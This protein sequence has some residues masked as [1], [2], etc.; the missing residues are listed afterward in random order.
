[1][2]LSTIND[3]SSLDGHSKSREIG[4][5]YMV[6][7]IS[8]IDLLNQHNAPKDIDYLSIDTEGSEYEILNAFDFKKYKI[9]II[10]CEHNYTPNRDKINLLLTSNGYERKYETISNFDDW[11]V[12]K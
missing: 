6:D 3:F 9:K 12:L 10:T 2:E 4:E 7:T 5:K 1:M 8:L 11:Y